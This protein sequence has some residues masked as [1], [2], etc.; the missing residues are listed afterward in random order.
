[1]L[2]KVFNKVGWYFKTCLFSQWILVVEMQ[3]EYGCVWIV[4]WN[5]LHHQHQQ[6][7][8][9]AQNTSKQLAQC[10]FHHAC[11]CMGSVL[12]SK[13]LKETHA[14][15][16]VGQSFPEVGWYFKTCLFSL[17][18]L[19]VKSAVRI[20]IG[21]DGFFPSLTSQPTP[22]APHNRTKYQQTTCAMQ[23]SPCL[24]LHGFCPVFQHAERD[25]YSRLCWSKF[26]IRL[27]GT[28][29]LVCFLCK[30]WWWKMQFEYGCVWIFFASLTSQPT[31]AAPHN[32]TKY[33]QTT[34][35]MQS[36]PC[37]FLYGFCP[38]FQHAERDTCSRLC[39][40]KFSIRSVGTVK[41]V[42]FLCEFWWWKVQL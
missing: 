29:K 5:S 9:N 8:T 27:V 39:W 25:T 23:F 15:D 1:M 12:F 30:F 14:A 11:S 7:H 36:S 38:V 41:F 2:V 13:M 37:V 3:F 19:V 18:T 35:A 34:C 26:S 33:Q 17:W 32:R 16:Y 42:C 20:W 31:P 40:P 24:F 21:L 10:N 6:H 4:F 28:V 22:A